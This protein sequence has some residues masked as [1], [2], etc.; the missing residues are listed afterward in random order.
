M[1]QV[2][3]RG[4]R[5]RKIWNIRKGEMEKYMKEKEVDKRETFPCKNKEIVKA[6]QDHRKAVNH[7]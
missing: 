3:K 6:R 1:M 5:T 4:Q 2:K 7:H